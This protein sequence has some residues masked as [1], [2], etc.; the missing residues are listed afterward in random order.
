MKKHLFYFAAALAVVSMFGCSKDATTGT[1]QGGE[2]DSNAIGF[3]TFLDK[4][5]KGVSTPAGGLKQD[6]WVN[7]YYDAIGDHSTT[8]LDPSFMYMQQVSYTGSGFTYSPV[9]FWPQT[10]DVEFYAW[11][12]YSPANL[13][14]TTPTEKTSKGYPVFTYTVK[15]LVASQEDLLVSGLGDQDGTSGSVNL[16]FS[17]ALTKVGFVARAGGDYASLGV[18]I[19]VKNI[20]VDSVINNGTFSYDNYMNIQDTARWWTTGN[21]PKLSYAPA[22]AVSGGVTVG[23]Y[24]NNGFVQLNGSDQFLLMIP[25]N[26]TGSKAQLKITYDVFYQDNT[27]TEEFVKTIPL[28]GS[29][30]W[31]GSTYVTYAFTISLN[32]ITFTATVNDW[33][34][35]QDNIIILPED[36]E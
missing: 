10:G 17:H 2:D 11:T 32:M 14:F 28:D 25:Q 7:G 31:R 35:K 23:T 5:T 33:T 15:D 3:K 24:P 21:S 1:G 20:E 29:I 27:P 22:L 6:F 13:K 26:F 30:S 19:K 36:N 18:N 8:G 9:K 12:P 4:S 34:T 16:I